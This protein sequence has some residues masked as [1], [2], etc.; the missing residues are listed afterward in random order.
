M[1]K[2]DKLVKIFQNL[3]YS[4][5]RYSKL[6][7][8][9]KEDFKFAQGNQWED[10]DV[11]AL[12][13]R[14]ILA[15]TINKIKP[16]IKLI[17]GIERQSRTD[18]VA[19]PEGAEDSLVAEISTKLTK[20]VVKMSQA[21]LKLSDQFKTGVIGGACYLEPYIDYS[22][23]LIDGE[24][25]FK[26][27]SAMNVFPD[28]DGKEYDLSD[29]RFISKVSWGLTADE[30]IMLFPEK[31]SVIKAMEGG[32]RFNLD[33]TNDGIAVESFGYTKGST[34]NFNF[35]DPTPKFDLIDH[36]YKTLET[37]Y[38]VAEPSQGLLEE[39]ETKEE[40]EAVL[41]DVP[42]ARIIKREMPVIMLCQIVGDEI[43]YEGKAW[44]YPAWKSYPIIPFYADLLTENL[45]DKSIEIQGIVRNIKSLQLE[46][47]KRR[48]QELQHIN[49]SANSGFDIEEGQLTP[50]QEEHLKRF[51]SSPGFVVKRKR[52]TA[53]LNR[54]TPMPLS[55]GHA[56]LAAENAQ[57]LKEAS[58]VNPDLLANDSMSQSGRAILLKQRQGLAM[59]QEMLDNFATTKKMVGKFILSQL[60]EIF[61]TEN[62]L[63]V[64]GDSYIK[65]NF[66]VPVTL[67]IERALTKMENEEQLTEL[68]EQTL[69][70]Y[71]NNNAQNPVVDPQ[72][73]QLAMMVDMD[74]AKEAVNRVLTDTS[75]GKYDVSI[76]EGPFND[77]IRLANFMEITDLAKQGIP[78][79]PDIII[80][81]SSIPES[82]KKKII[83]R[84]QEQAMAQA[85]Q[86][87]QPKGNPSKGNQNE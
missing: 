70:M 45:E 19:F 14:G 81:L 54:I 47:N 86:A 71:P 69:L 40:A 5:E 77:T 17:T 13:E 74:L 42:T 41:L 67:V 43:M 21:E 58:G 79:P 66:E 85:Q 3:K 80:G 56:Q 84:L 36:Y 82:E 1:N 22:Y 53:P 16:I 52:G 9:M 12:D 72:T 75:L 20:N 6:H 73:M 68:E 61:T 65:E 46:F 44:T 23:D 27:I 49:S 29:H 4:I 8:E 33:N 2:Q 30:L 10:S 35:D 15:L 62:A 28:P 51:G 18:F 63:R 76:G 83:V 31:K 64:I 55:Q 57:D 39:K 24:L 34:E 87:Q 78:I 32:W 38:F 25:K 11:R 37:K 59:I 7:R 60:K 50:E 48:T 26:K